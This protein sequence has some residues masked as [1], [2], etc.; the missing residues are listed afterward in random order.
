[1]ADSGRPDPSIPDAGT[2]G[3]GQRLVTLDR[4]DEVIRVLSSTLGSMWSAVNEIT[5]LRPT[6]RPQFNVSIFGSARVGEA[7]PVYA[8]V[9]RLA[10]GLAEMGCGIVTGGGPGFMQA[11]NEGASEAGR[12]DASIGIRIHLDFEQEVNPFVSQAFEHGTFFTRLHQFVLQSA[13]FVVVPGGI[14][15]ALEL[16]MVWQLLQV[17]HVTDAP[18]IFVGD[19]WEE[20]VDWARRHMVE[21]E[22]PM[23]GAD[24]I[25]IPRCVQTVE[26][27]LAIVGEHHDAWT[28]DPRWVRA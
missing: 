11:A 23:A 25:A 2:S 22:T 26:E 4:Q 7:D 8:E 10:K 19:M 27:A 12:S 21:C 5:R 3:T 6:E 14:G 24:D 9:R 17:R 18:L 16:F 28:R 20:L 15:T 1:M 13:A